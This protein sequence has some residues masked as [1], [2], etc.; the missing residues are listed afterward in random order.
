MRSHFNFRLLLILI[1][2]LQAECLRA[3][4]YSFSLESAANR[5]NVEAMV[6]VGKC[7]ASGNGIDKD[8]EKA[9]K[10][11]LKAA[12]FGDTGAQFAVYEA[13]LKGYGVE[14]NPEQAQYWLDQYNKKMQ[15]EARKHAVVYNK[16]LVKKAQNGDAESQFLLA[17]CYYN[18]DGVLQDFNETY[19]WSM[20]AAQQNYPEGVTAVGQLYYKGQGVAQNYEE[21]VRWFQKGEQ[22]N[23]PMAYYFLGECYE[24]GYGV[25]ENKEMAFN[26]YKNAAEGGDRGGMSSL[27]SCYYF[28]QGTAENNEEAFKWFS[29]AADLGDAYSDQQMGVCYQFGWGV[30]PDS[31]KAFK[32]IKKAADAGYFYS[33]K[34][35][36]LFYVWGYACEPDSVLAIEWWM[37]ALEEGNDY[38]CGNYIAELMHE[39]EQNEMALKLLELLAG[40]NDANAMNTIG[41]IYYDKSEEWGVEPDYKK[42]YEYLNK[43]IE[44]GSNFAVGNLGEMYLKGVYVK[45]DL[46]KAFQLIK[47][48]AES[49]IDPN[50]DAMR[51]LAACYRYGYGTK[52]SAASE[53]YWLKKAAEYGDEMAIEQKDYGQK[54]RQT[55]AT[56]QSW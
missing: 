25:P 42:A 23:E 15:K 29:K 37:K 10:W 16:K 3:Q 33:M 9:F 24:N 52:K 49:E 28:G 7:Y 36:G 31:I 18:G 5:G 4:K 53:K 40:Q 43:A 55:A 45:K 39:K 46:K 12:K 51:R 2:C 14:A 11:F 13:Y 6:E 34:T 54:K 20:K 44:L 26:C 30:E 32:H 38:E 27:A 47:Q 41:C 48:S 17:G 1:A 35:L 19:Y 8:L 50:P 56:V 22:L 21:A